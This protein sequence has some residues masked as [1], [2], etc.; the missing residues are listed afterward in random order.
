MG[1]LDLIGWELGGDGQGGCASE[2]DG[3]ARG[4]GS[5]DQRDSRELGRREQ[6]G[7]MLRSQATTG[8]EREVEGLLGYRP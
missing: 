6:S 1:R 5:M 4:E 7:E 3:Q 8:K 2:A